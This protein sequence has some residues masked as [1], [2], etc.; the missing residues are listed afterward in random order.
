LNVIAVGMGN[1]GSLII[2]GPS[3]GERNMISGA[4]SGSGIQIQS[5]VALGPGGC[6]IINNIIGANQNYSAAVPNNW[7]INLAG[8]GCLVQDNRIAGNSH[9]AIWI[10]GGLANTVRRNVI[11]IASDGSSLGFNDGWGVRVSGNYNQIGAPAQAT[12]SGTL[13]AN[14]IAYMLKG[15]VS[16]ASLVG[17]SSNSIRG[18]LIG[19]NGIDGYAPAI[20]LGADGNTANDAGDSDTGA[21]ALQNYPAASAVKYT[22]GYPQAGAQDVYAYLYGDLV[23]A[24]GVYKVDAYFYDGTCHSGQRGQAQSYLGSW[25]A[26]IGAGGT[27]ARFNFQAQLPN[28]AANAAVAFTATDSSG[29][30]SELGTCYPVSKAVLLDDIF[31]DDYEGF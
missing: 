13:D 18:N 26:V 15:G 24:P 5:S 30:T 14:F 8:S 9:D 10:N 22:Y 27:D 29:N 3:P 4:A 21:N 11:G 25:T 20:D 16:V 17:A 7:G 23:G 12:L 2:G 28:V 1:T 6:Q 31:K 19:N